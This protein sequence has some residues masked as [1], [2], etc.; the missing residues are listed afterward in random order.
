[1]K[2]VV[3]Y[4]LLK[5][6]SDVVESIYSYDHIDLIIIVDILKLE[7]KRIHKLEISKVYDL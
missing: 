2:N 5:V 1:L 7:K 6:N 3:K 4:F